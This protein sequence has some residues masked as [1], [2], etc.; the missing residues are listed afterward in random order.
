MGD[1]GAVVTKAVGIGRVELLKF[2][3]SLILRQAAFR[4]WADD[5]GEI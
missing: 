2:L 5:S 4:S 3:F 1:G